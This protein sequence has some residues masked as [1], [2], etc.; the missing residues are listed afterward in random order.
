MSKNK[1]WFIESTVEAGEVIINDGGSA[2]DFRIEGD[3]DPNLLVTDGSA[4]KVGIGTNAPATKLE[5]TSDS[6]GEVIAAVNHNV[7]STMPAEIVMKK[8]RGSRS[9]PGTIVD[10]DEL[11]QI[12]FQGFDG[13]NYDE[14]AHIKVASTSV[15]SDTSSMTFHSDKFVLDTGT[16][17]F[18]TAG[19]AVSSIATTV[20]V[21]SLD[22]ELCTAKAAF[23][24]LAGGT[25]TFSNTTG[26]V[27]Y[28]NANSSGNVGKVYYLS[29]HSSDGTFAPSILE[30]N[31]SRVH[32]GGDVDSSYVFKVT[33]ASAI[34]GATTITGAT[35]VTGALTVGVDDTGHDVKFFGATAGTF[36]LWDE[37]ADSLLLGENQKGVTL[38]AF[39]AGDGNYLHWDEAN[40]KL[41]VQGG[42]E[43][44]KTTSNE[45]LVK[46]KFKLKEDDDTFKFYSQSASQEQDIFQIYNESDVKSVWVEDTGELNVQSNIKFNA[47]SAGAIK[48]GSLGIGLASATS[49]INFDVDSAGS[50]SFALSQG[51]VTRLL[52]DASGNMSYIS[53]TVIWNSS[54]SYTIKSP[55]LIVNDTSGSAT[56]GVIEASKLTTSSGNLT[57]D[58]AGGTVTVDD[59]LTVTGTLTA[60]TVDFSETA[61]TTFA[62][63][64]T[65]LNLKLKAVNITDSSLPI[66]VGKFIH[67][68]DSTGNAGTAGIA[69]KYVHSDDSMIISTKDDTDS[70]TLAPGYN[71]DAGDVKIGTSTSKQSNLICYGDAT[72]SGNL[73]VSGTLSGSFDIDNTTSADF[74]LDSAGNGPHFIVGSDNLIQTTTSDSST[75]NA[76][77]TTGILLDNV[78]GGSNILTLQSY[79]QEIQLTPGSNAA[80][81]RYVGIT[82]SID[83]AQGGATTYNRISGAGTKIGAIA[84]SAFA[85]T[86]DLS[87]G[88]TVIYSDNGK[89]QIDAS[90]DIASITTAD[91]IFGATSLA[92]ANSSDNK[93]VKLYGNNTSAY[94]QWS[95]ANNK[96]LVVGTAAGTTNFQVHTGKAIFGRTGVDSLDVDFFG[97]AGEIASVD[98]G[99]SFLKVSQ[100]FRKVPEVKAATVTLTSQ[101]SGRPIAIKNKTADSTYTL[102]AVAD[103]LNYKFMIVERTGSYDVNIVTPSQTNFFFGSVLHVDTDNSQAV[104]SSDNNSNNKLNMQLLDPG[105]MIE[106]ACDGTNWYI[107]GYAV[108]TEAP[109]FSDV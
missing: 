72:V 49:L 4:D 33:G 45:I 66:A 3:T 107:S 102:P 57:I 67:P 30:A 99:D 53:P 95:Q 100:G 26:S 14:L 48:M 89:M 98:A 73:T 63:D 8:G 47:A 97:A 56:A 101:E 31:A 90:E 35:Q 71:H 54:T 88:D 91:F 9:L 70:I 38:K 11:G 74:Q 79:N 92:G 6:V 24:A 80:G 1:N 60:T 7:S 50:K 61:S 44:G 21:N 93:E 55:K 87:T 77:H 5:V 82:G 32:V 51:T 2:V 105:S 46:G 86:S 62:L 83:V 25:I 94:T 22:T 39:G 103:G 17:Q 84:N 27:A 16:L 13:S 81:E 15:S 37:S 18:G 108:S 109:V 65:G 19:Q 20:D 52:I 36:L 75:L 85:G 40:N 29:N 42:I 34:V 58:S 76:I 43:L 23:T 106:V 41:N 10:G 12:S 104:V 78:A 96:L 69:T 68:V 59:N 64:K 28:T